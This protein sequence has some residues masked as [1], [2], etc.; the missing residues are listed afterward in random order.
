M[1]KPLGFPST[2]IFGLMDL[3]GIDLAPHINAS[4]GRLLPT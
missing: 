2:G 4:M 1:G 3:V